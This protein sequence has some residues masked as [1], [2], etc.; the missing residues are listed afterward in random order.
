MSTATGISPPSDTDHASPSGLGESTFSTT[1][2]PSLSDSSPSQ[3][4]IT[5]SHDLENT[6]GVRENSFEEFIK[7]MIEA[8]M[9]FELK[10]LTPDKINGFASTGTK[11]ITAESL[12]PIYGNIRDEHQSFV[13]ASKVTRAAAAKAAEAAKVAKGSRDSI[14]GGKR[15]SIKRKHRSI[16]TIL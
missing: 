9:A 13:Y 2:P 6:G 3:A 8:Y 10:D 4:G 12:D 7:G 15:S 11:K 5:V 1:A 14:G 16:R